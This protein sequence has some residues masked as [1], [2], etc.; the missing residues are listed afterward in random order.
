M[1]GVPIPGVRILVHN[2]ADNTDTTSA[3]A[4]DGSFALNELKPGQYQIFSMVRQALSVPPITLEPHSASD[5]PMPSTSLCNR[6]WEHPAESMIL[7]GFETM[8]KR[9]EQLE[10]E[11]RE[12][13]SRRFRQIRSPLRRQTPAVSQESRLPLVAS[14]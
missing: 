5:S 1:E 3:S 12:M 13:G 7:K 8:Q 6:R 11:L 14:L 9:I 10:A 4:S 2:I